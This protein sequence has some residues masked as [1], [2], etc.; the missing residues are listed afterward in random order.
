MI[1]LASCVPVV[2]LAALS[3]AQSK[4]RV[5]A[6]PRSTSTW[7]LA[8]KSKEEVKDSVIGR[9]LFVMG[10]GVWSDGTTDSM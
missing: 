10:T 8:G 3:Q 6:W 7:G 5:P 9:N 4:P 1:A 2:A